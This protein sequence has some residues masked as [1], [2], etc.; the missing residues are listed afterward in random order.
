MNLQKPARTP[1]LW[2]FGA[3]CALAPF[4]G[5]VHVPSLA[6]IPRELG[7]TGSGASTISVYIFM[8]AATMIPQG[9]LSDR[10]G[11]RPLA[12][13][14]LVTLT[15]SSIAAALASSM[16]HLLIARALQGVAAAG[17]LVVARAAVR[18]SFEGREGTRAMSVLST[19]QTLG[20]AFAPVLGALV[21]WRWGFGTM[22]LAAAAILALAVPRWVETRPPAA[23]DEPGTAGGFVTLWSQPLFLPYAVALAAMASIY[24]AFI[25]AGPAVLVG[26]GELTPRDFSLVLL[27]GA[28]SC[29]LGN[30]FTRTTARLAASGRLA[31]VGAGVVGLAVAG[32]I[33]TWATGASASGWCCSYMLYMFGNGIMIPAAIMSAL[34]IPP[35]VVGLGA[36]I[37]GTVQFLLGALAADSVDHFINPS[38]ALIFVASTAALV[39]VGGLACAQLRARAL[40]A[41]ALDS[42]ISP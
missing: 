4:G 35:R 21:G 9:W 6:S 10:L 25:A 19:L 39:M 32:L 16:T 20:L 12:L 28:C 22:G 7:S 18:D 3:A 15:V 34:Q 5:G 31:L 30:L 26:S 2:L 40:V 23:M 41:P 14:T 13:A 29:A 8:L 37:L 24:F 38:H 11:R 36:S 27:A 42:R 33:T 1:S 17:V